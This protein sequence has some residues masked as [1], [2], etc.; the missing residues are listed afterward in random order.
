[1]KTKIVASLVLA[2]SAC[3]LITQAQE[4]KK[5]AGKTAAFDRFKELAGEW[6]G[7]GKHGDMEHEARI[8][9]K[10]T[11]GGSAVVETIDPGGEHEMVTVIHPDGDAIL[12]THYCM[13]GNQPHMKAMPKSGDNKIAFEFVK[14]TNLKSD[15]DMYMRSVTFTFMAKDT[16]STEW[17]NYADGK[18]AGRATFTLKRK[19]VPFATRPQQDRCCRRRLPATQV[20]Q[21]SLPPRRSFGSNQLRCAEHTPAT[22]RAS[23]A[24]MRQNATI[25]PLGKG[26]FLDA[27]NYL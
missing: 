7:K 19:K 6:V 1:M 18:E 10:V 4:A 26:G 24:P 27:N 8:V 23:N 20:A 12:L 5:G 22:V 16:L 3:A 21:S 9:Y 11:A 25:C 13:L 15:K 17:T 14:A 2:L